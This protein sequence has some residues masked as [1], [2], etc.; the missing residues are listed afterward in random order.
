M[1]EH[2]K[3]TTFSVPLPQKDKFE[4]KQ[5][6]MT[7]TQDK[8]FLLSSLKKRICNINSSLL[9]IYGSEYIPETNSYEF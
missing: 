2:D 8:I 6:Q 5:S 7:N 1:G 4:N 9:V 3:T